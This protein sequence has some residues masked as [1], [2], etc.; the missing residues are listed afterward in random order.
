[1]RLVD[2]DVL[3]DHFHGVTAATE[4]V[5]S[6]LLEDGELFIS[7][8]SIAEI[9]TGIRQGEEDD[10][11][12]LLA[13]F[14]IVEADEAIAR[15]A[16]KYLNEFQKSHALDLGDALIA[17]SAKVLD[18]ELVTRNARHYPMQDL[19]LRVPYERGRKKR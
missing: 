4:Y 10:T 9:L 12:A 6:A 17:A 14:S 8:I 5:S 16:G 15:L 2:T 7:I 3:I 19:A 18:A 1:M 11:E 13:L